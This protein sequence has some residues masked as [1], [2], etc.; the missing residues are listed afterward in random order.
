MNRRRGLA[1]APPGKGRAYPTAAL[2]YSKGTTVHFALD[3]KIMK[4]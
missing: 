2:Q 4:P 3:S 1:G